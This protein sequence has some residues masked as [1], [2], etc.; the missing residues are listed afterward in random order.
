[1]T[2]GRAGL[3]RRAGGAGPG[4]RGA[5][6]AQGLAKVTAAYG[7]DGP[8]KSPAARE[9]LSPLAS[10]HRSRLR[11]LK[12]LCSSPPEKRGLS[13]V[14]CCVLPQDLACSRPCA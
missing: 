13:P 5:G 14:K 10:E 6:A 4:A 2:D 11:P 3:W 7:S 8:T 1:M 9:D 12:A